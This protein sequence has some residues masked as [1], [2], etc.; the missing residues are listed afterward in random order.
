MTQE[1]S[2]K[3]PIERRRDDGGLGTVRKTYETPV[4]TV[5]GDFENLTKG[6]NGSSAD[7]TGTHVSK[8]T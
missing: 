4:V 7:L 5:W 3:T 8:G 1:Q 2:G 6:G